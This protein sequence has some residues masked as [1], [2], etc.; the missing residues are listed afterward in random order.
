ME[1]SNFNGVVRFSNGGNSSD[2]R[3]NAATVQSSIGTRITS[4]QLTISP[5]RTPPPRSPMPDPPFQTYLYHHQEI[6][7]NLPTWTRPNTRKI[8]SLQEE[9]TPCD[10][11]PIVACLANPSILPTLQ[12]LPLLST[13]TPLSSKFNFSRIMQ[14]KL[15]QTRVCLSINYTHLEIPR[16]AQPPR[17]DKI[18]RTRY[19]EFRI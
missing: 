19:F 10:P 1:W 5:L 15:R 12:S 18:D 9:R 4:Y 11:Q 8:I 7:R 3:L 17:R 2:G 13:T 16:P 14:G 6:Y